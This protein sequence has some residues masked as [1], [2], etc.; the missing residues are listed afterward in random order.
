SGCT[1]RGLLVVLV[2]VLA[3]VGVGAYS[4]LSGD[5][6]GSGPAPVAVRFVGAGIEGDCDALRETLLIP[7]DE[8]ETFDEDCAEFVEMIQEGGDDVVAEV[9]STS[10][11]DETE[12]T[13]TV[14]VEYRTR[15]GEPRTGD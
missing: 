3:A 8:L 2:L 14:A 6:G 11:E 7:E 10:I 9:L 1:A 12:D 4:L 15:G 13:A 5:A